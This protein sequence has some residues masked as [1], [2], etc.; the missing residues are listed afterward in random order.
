M[1]KFISLNEFRKELGFTQEE[2]ANALGT[3]RN[4]I[5]LVE[6]GVRPF[7]TS[8]KAKIEVLFLNKEFLKSLSPSTIKNLQEKITINS[9]ILKYVNDHENLVSN[10]VNSNEFVNNDNQSSSNDLMLKLITVEARLSSIE[11]I[12]LKLLAK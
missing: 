8:L 12:L 10:T 5:S 4:Y 9:N 11:Q 3:S 1:F 7:S 6:K 2:L